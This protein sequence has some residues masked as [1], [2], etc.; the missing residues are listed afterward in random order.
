SHPNDVQAKY[1]QRPDDDDAGNYVHPLTDM[2]GEN[3]RGSACPEVEDELDDHARHNDVGG[4]SDCDNDA[5]QRA[6][7]RTGRVHPPP[8][9]PRGSAFQLGRV[10]GRSTQCYPVPNPG[11][12]EPETAL[13]SRNG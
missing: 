11:T 3:H 5:L 6:S 4:A 7:F 10:G 1:R 13:V 12:E 8:Q 2:W 9:A